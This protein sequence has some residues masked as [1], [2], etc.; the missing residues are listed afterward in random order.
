MNYTH[1][2]NTFRLLP[3]HLCSTQL[4]QSNKYQVTIQ[5]L[6]QLFS[7]LICAGTKCQCRCFGNRMRNICKAELSYV[8]KWSTR[9]YCQYL[10]LRGGW[11]TVSWL[12]SLPRID[13]STGAILFGDSLFILTNGVEK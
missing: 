4:V 5:R 10:K 3:I 9:A 11:K 2:R 7:W 12:C 6:S 1:T 8:S 13:A